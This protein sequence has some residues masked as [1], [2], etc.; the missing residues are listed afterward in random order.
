MSELGVVRIGLNAHFLNG[1]WRWAE[2]HHIEPHVR[3]TVE[4]KFRARF[5][6]ARREVRGSEDIPRIQ[7][8]R[9]ARVL[10]AGSER[11]KHNGF[12]R[13][14]EASDLC[15][16]VG[17]ARGF[18]GEQ[19]RFSRD[20]HRFVGHPRSRERS[21][22]LARCELNPILTNFES[23]QHGSTARGRSQQRKPIQAAFVADLL[24]GLRSGC[25]RR[26]SRR[27]GI[28]ARWSPLHTIDCLV[29][30]ALD[31]MGREATS[32]QTLE[33]VNEVKRGAASS[34]PELKARQRAAEV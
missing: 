31:A 18:R 21:S 30:M 8:P 6:T 32:K 13:S 7:R 2:T 16:H 4:Q 20:R 14:M 9:T 34:F 11:E 28:E 12:R 23:L 10:D 26:E 5:R 24:P 33:R 29:D 15:A 19:R 1:V 22:C 17:P 27:R 25:S 3:N